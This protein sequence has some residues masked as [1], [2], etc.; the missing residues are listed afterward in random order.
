MHDQGAMVAWI[1]KKERPDPQK[2]IFGLLR[3]RNSGAE[4]GMDKNQVTPLKAVGK[5]LQ[6]C[7][8]IAVTASA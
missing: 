8:G 2:I 6:K 4:S 7:A 5:R 1:L 3:Q